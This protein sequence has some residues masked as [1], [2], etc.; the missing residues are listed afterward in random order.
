ME[1]MLLFA[2]KKERFRRPNIFLE[3]ENQ[4]IKSHTST[5]NFKQ[6]HAKP[7]Y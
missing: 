6:L 4:Y 2:F 3:Y 7:K 1:H 5:S